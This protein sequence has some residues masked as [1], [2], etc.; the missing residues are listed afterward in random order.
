MDLQPIESSHVEAAG[1][2]PVTREMH[3][4]FKGGEGLFKMK[5]VPTELYQKFLSAKSKGGF[6]AAYIRNKFKHEKVNSPSS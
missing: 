1:Y 2:D 6:F 4:R 5:D 3:V